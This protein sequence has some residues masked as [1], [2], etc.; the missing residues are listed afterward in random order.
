LAAREC[1]ALSSLA[2]FNLELPPGEERGGCVS[3]G[4]S[5]RS[6]AERLS[7]GIHMQQI[8]RDALA[9][10]F[11]AFFACAFA[12][13]LLTPVILFLIFRFG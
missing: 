10:A 4:G 2:R 6:G 12:G 13:A 9:C 5:H 1:A 3:P 11:L 8:G 7:K